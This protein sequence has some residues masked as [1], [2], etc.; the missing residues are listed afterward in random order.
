MDVRNPAHEIARL[1]G[2]HRRGREPVLAQC[3][4]HIPRPR[5][6]HPTFTSLADERG[7]LLDLV[8]ELLPPPERLPQD[9]AHVGAHAVARVV[10]GADR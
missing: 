1:I 4:D 5:F 8:A 6:P 10:A 3:L 9:R 2:H 7:A